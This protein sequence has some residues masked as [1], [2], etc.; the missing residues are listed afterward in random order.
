MRVFVALDIPEAVRAALAG[1]VAR[2]QPTCRGARWVR[3]AG[4]HVTLKFIGEISAEKVARVR[5]AL[6]TIRGTGPVEM[7]FRNVGFFPNARHPRVFWTGIEAGPELVGLATQI[8]AVLEPLDI[9]RESRAFK[10]HLTLARFKS[11]DGLPQLRDELAKM[12]A[13]EFGSARATEFHLYESKLRREGAEYTRL[14]SF[15]LGGS[16]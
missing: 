11:E 7:Q 3:V 16:A 4:L 10:P 8:E 14:A 1:L 6:G 15:P 9:P 13:L 12:S 2:L 5:A